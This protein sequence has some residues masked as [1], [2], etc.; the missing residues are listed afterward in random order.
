MF[1]VLY[2]VDGGC[3]T[4]PGELLFF[5]DPETE[6][7]DYPKLKFQVKSISWGQNGNFQL[8]NLPSKHSISDPL[9]SSFKM[10]KF[11]K[12]DFSIYMHLST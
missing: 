4:D 5:V 10:F 3:Y 2:E 11:Q 6:S 12:L 9:N 1:H 7:E 8:K